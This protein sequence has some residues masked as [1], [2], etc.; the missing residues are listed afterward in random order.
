MKTK[1][2]EKLSKEDLKKIVGGFDLEDYATTYV[3]PK[4]KN[5]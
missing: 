2:F 1:N 3:V 4:K 5:D